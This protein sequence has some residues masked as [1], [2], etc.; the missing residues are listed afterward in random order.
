MELPMNIKRVIVRFVVPLL[1][2]SWLIWPA[3]AMGGGEKLNQPVPS[4]PSESF[5]ARG[6]Q[7]PLGF[8]AREN[9]ENGQ[10]YFQVRQAG[11]TLVV[12][13]DETIY[14]FAPAEGKA[15][16]AVLRLAFLGSESQHEP[17]GVEN[18]PGRL[19]YLGG[20]EASLWQTNI[21]LFSRV[22]CREIYP[23]VAAVYYGKDGS[24]EYDLKL[25]AGADPAHIRLGIYGADQ[26]VLNDRGDLEINV[27]SRCLVH[28]KPVAYQAAGAG[29]QPVDAAFKIHRGPAGSQSWEIAFA[30]GSFNPGLALVIDPVMQFSSF[31]GGSGDDQAYSIVTDDAACIYVCGHA[32]S[33]DFPTLNSARPHGGGYDAF[34]AKI[35]TQEARLVYATFIGGSG[36]D[37]AFRIAV[38]RQGCAIVGGVTSSTD[39]PV[40]NACQPMFGGGG[41][42]GF[43]AKLDASGSSLIFSTYLGGSGNDEI[44]GVAVD[45]SGKIYVAGDTS[46]TNLPLAKAIQP[47]NAGGIDGFV[48]K[49]EAGG[50]LK[51]CTYLGGSGPFDCAIGVAADR[52]GNAYVTGYT[53]SADFPI[54]HALVPKYQGGY[55]AFVAKFNPEGSALVYSTFLGGSDNDIG[56][57]IAV[58]K[59]GSA[60]VS[61]DT[62]S[63]N[64]PTV[65]PW[66]PMLDGARDVF[67]S[68]LSAG[69]DKLTYS[70]YLGGSGEEVAVA[71]ID[72]QDNIYLAGLTSSTNFPMVVPVQHSYGGGAWDAFVA[73]LSAKDHQLLFASYMGGSGIDQAAGLAVDDRGAIYLA[74]ATTSRDFP[75][76]NRLSS[77][78][79]SGDY[80][81]FV[82]QISM[83]LLVSDAKP[84]TINPTAKEIQAQP[85]ALKPA[86]IKPEET[87][88]AEAK[89]EEVK[90]A[91]TKPDENK[92]VE[93]KPSVIKPE[94][95]PADAA[96]TEESKPVES[97]PGAAKPVP[98]QETK[99]VV[100]PVPPP[101]VIN[102]PKTETGSGNPI[103]S[104]LPPTVGQ[105]VA[106]TME[107]ATNQLAAAAAKA[108]ETVSNL[109][110]QAQEKLA[111]PPVAE[112]MA[113]LLRSPLLNN[114]LLINGD[115]ET[116]EAA[117]SSYSQVEIPG[118]EISNRLTVLPYG[119]PGGF[120][121]L[122]NL[123]PE[124]RG[125][126]FFV[127]GPSNAV[128]TAFQTI[129]LADLAPLIDAGQVKYK[130]SAYLGGIKGQEDHAKV[131]AVF[132]KADGIPTGQI[133]IGPVTLTDRN[134]DTQ[135]LLRSTTGLL[136][137]GTRK[138]EVLVIVTRVNGTYN[139]G[140]V[141]CVSLILAPRQQRFPGE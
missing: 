100:V 23:G 30:L 42:D 48:A 35:N 99:E 117:L 41:K 33:A 18:A 71:T 7:K 78:H 95:N 94:E 65:K 68:Q 66:Q 115:A 81:A 60:F 126:Q 141:D 1:G 34:V 28:R 122:T 101:S 74:G 89:P 93:V 135:L 133:S 50:A 32:T 24:L 103:S 54:R 51:Y 85:E 132:K 4:A 5:I 137:P 104:L 56:R 98:G 92:P 29:R 61:G 127:G 39:F 121:T 58:D 44:A 6:F 43:L 106:K 17:E 116:G 13:K 47:A 72:A 87:K 40:Q 84:T 88:S 52:E 118:W 27:G 9:P 123:G 86:E 2:G 31:L 69:G 77:A 114:N 82:V 11:A 110:A 70:T 63:T 3:A 75:T 49:L 20:S 113:V 109:A 53:S 25:A 55:D 131:E 107:E 10:K 73:K 134:Y 124:N 59:K 130:L 16:P 80:D 120:P 76:L 45:E 62:S 19:N 96:K 38:D 136:P 105:P 128:S 139:D 8:E 15:E 57:S 90:P 79:G 125:K 140:L 22:E 14:R 37:R 21:P 12:K 119:M 112:A 102:A 64:F 26:V 129:I 97:K 91:E 111:T 83:S 46:S 36:Q 108:S 138:V 67:V